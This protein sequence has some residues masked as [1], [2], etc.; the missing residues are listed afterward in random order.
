LHSMSQTKLLSTLSAPQR[1]AP[2]APGTVLPSHRG[3]SK[4]GSDELF[5]TSSR[6]HSAI[7]HRDLAIAGSANM[8]FVKM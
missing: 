4:A 3:S 6:R 5:H 2:S 1:F 8:R 7:G